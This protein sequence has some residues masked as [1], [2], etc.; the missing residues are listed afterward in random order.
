[1]SFFLCG[2]DLQK[3][4][5][6]ESACCRKLTLLQ[7]L[8]SRYCAGMRR[9]GRMNDL[10]GACGIAN[11]RKRQQFLLAWAPVQRLPTVPP[12]HPNR[13]AVKKRGKDAL[14]DRSSD[15]S[16]LPVVMDTD[17]NAVIAEQGVTLV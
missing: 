7:F 14:T 8:A 10:A 2:I 11:S 13:D 1:M 4:L 3:Q 16:P 15:P 12:T 6:T 17:E 5:S 9:V